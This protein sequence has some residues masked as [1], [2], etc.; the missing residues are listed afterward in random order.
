MYENCL[1][2]SGDRK[3][4]LSFPTGGRPPLFGLSQEYFT[5]F[6]NCGM[7]GLGASDGFLFCGIEHRHGAEGPAEIHL[8]GCPNLGKYMRSLF[9]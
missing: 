5:D 8:T 9:F 6:G 3:E 7:P 2:G 4:I 1:P